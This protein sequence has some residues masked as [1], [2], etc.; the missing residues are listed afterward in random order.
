MKRFFVV[1]VLT[2]VVIGVCFVQYKFLNDCC[3]KMLSSL[4]LLEQTCNDENFEKAEKLARDMEDTW[5]TYEKILS[6]F[7]ENTE[8]S[9]AGEHIGGISDLATSE[10]KEDMLNQIA[11]I[12]IQFI[13]IKTSNS[14]RFESIF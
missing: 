6:Y 3:S 10:T 5:I 1:I 11:V 12:R 4:D 8:L 2:A 7:L 13:H 9:A 14:V